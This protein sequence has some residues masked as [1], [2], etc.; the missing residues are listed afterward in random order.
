MLL[1]RNQALIGL[2]AVVV[3]SIATAF[4]LL[5]TRGV[6]DTGTEMTA[7]FEDAAGLDVDDQVLVAGVRSGRVL[8]VELLDDGLVEV[9]FVV[10][11][12][13]P[14]D[15]R[16]RITV[17]NLLGR[18]QLQLVAGSAWDQL[19]AD[20]D[21]IPVGQTSTPVDV[22]EFGE[23][24]EGLARETDEVAL[25][26]MV[27]ALA[28]ITEGQR[29][30]VETLLDGLRQVSR[31]I[32]G[33]EE[34]LE[35]TI[36]RT[37]DLFAAFRDR[38]DEI[39]RIIDSF[40][41]TLDMLVDRRSEVER[42]LR[43]TAD[44]SEVLADLV[45]DER[46]RIDRV[47]TRLNESLEIVD[48]NQVDIAHFFAYAGVALEGFAN[49]GYNAEGEDNEFWANMRVQ[50]FGA[51][52]VD[53]LFGC[54]GTLDRQ[55][56]DILGEDP[57]TCDEQDAEPTPS[58]RDPTSIGHEERQTADDRDPQP[59]DRSSSSNASMR[60]FFGMYGAPTSEAGR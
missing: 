22:P 55:L 40:G 46:T 50:E 9:G 37:E 54:G 24:T 8:S 56:D 47:L 12:D 13:L 35:T 48:R 49:I 15:S 52:G 1:E 3:I 25:D 27:T 31:V 19:L 33:R 57:R 43:E 30:E 18:R 6:F 41:S 26:A 59:M 28:D 39:V 45:V 21:T 38:D 42:L 60:G 32:S 16:A 34:E 14:A 10:D 36:D 58:E 23:E 7:L 4:G 17:Q 29:E 2:V 20:D 51:A 53:I 44:S 11:A 5:A